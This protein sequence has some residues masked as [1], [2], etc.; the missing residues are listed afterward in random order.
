M[1]FINCHDLVDGGFVVEIDLP[2]RDNLFV[3]KG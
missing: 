3:D 2:R 1:S